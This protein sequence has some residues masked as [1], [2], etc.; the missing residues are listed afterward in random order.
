M[1]AWNSS[2]SVFNLAAMSLRVL[3]GVDKRLYLILSGIPQTLD[4]V[5]WGK[6][7]V[8]RIP[9]IF[10]ENWRGSFDLGRMCAIFVVVF[11]QNSV[12]RLVI[13]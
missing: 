3:T 7:K 10:E 12:A 5:C 4:I 2:L 13:S 8:H 6:E 1:R 11:D 9:G